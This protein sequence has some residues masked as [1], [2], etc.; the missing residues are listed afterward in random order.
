A[1]LGGWTGPQRIQGRA[2]EAGHRA[3]LDRGTRYRTGGERRRSMSPVVGTP[4]NRVDGP[5]KVTGAARYTAE[6]VLPNIA[7]AAIVGATIPSGRVANIDTNVAMEFDGV[8][9]VLTHENLPKVAAEPHLLPSL[10][11]QAAPGESFFP[12]QDDVIHYANQPVAVV[13]ADSHERA[14]YAAARLPVAYAPEPS[15]TTIDEGRDKAYEAQTLF[16]G[17]MPG[18]NVRGDVDAGMANAEVRVDV[19]YRFAA[20]HHNPLE[21]SATTATWDGDR[22]TIYDS[23]QGVRASQLTVAQLL[24]IPLSDVRVITHFVGG[25]F[26]SK[27]M[28]WP[29]VTLAAMA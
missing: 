7:Y 2:D 6:I 10:V 26:G 16:G 25:G 5:D 29:H 18:R 8:L 11:G 9:A 19:S 1:C 17:L 27:A 23:T 12:M 20:N 22:L 28:V 21:P 14:Q 3:L 15:I 13:I 4:I 24:G